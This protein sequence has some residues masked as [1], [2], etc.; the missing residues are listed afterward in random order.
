MLLSES[1][2]Q[3]R[4][5]WLEG[6]TQR[7]SRGEAGRTVLSE[8]MERFFEMLVQAV[9]SGDPGWLKPVLIDWAASRTETDIENEE[10][11][12]SPV[13]NLIMD[14]LVETATRHL[15]EEDAIA[16][17]S[18]LIPILYYSYEQIAQ[19]EMRVR[20]GYFTARLEKVSTDLSRLDRSKSDFI[21]V[22]AHELKTPLTLIEGYASMLEDIVSK[23][24]QGPQAAMLMEGIHKGIFRLGVMINDMIDI[25]M[26]D[27]QMLS[28]KYQPTWINRLL[29]GLVVDLRDFVG[30]RQQVLEVEDFPGAD[31]MIFADSERLEQALRNVLT[32]AIKYTPDGGKITVTGRLLSGFIEI[33]V[34]DS[35]IGI[36]PED[37]MVIFNKFSSLGDVKLHSSSKIN[38]KGGGPGLGLPIAKGILEAHG[39]SIWVESEG[40]NEETLPGSVFHIL[41][42]MRKQPPDEKMA[43]LFESSHS[44]ELPND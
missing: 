7:L 27:N 31:E 23:T 37:Q 43:K 4:V 29:K 1:L 21:S 32:N 14:E 44:S 39:G 15:P 2:K 28:L 33:R 19:H 16:L 40:Y 10:I 26:I 17:I 25:S 24:D 8:E 30:E 11:T 5:P 9:E 20:V 36:A 22:A 34:E 42:P 41:L 18:G 12:L 6:I 3:I 13:L 35:G 38:F